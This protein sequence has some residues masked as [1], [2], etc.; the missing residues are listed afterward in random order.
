MQLAWTAARGRFCLV[1]DAVAA[2]G[3]GDG[4]FQLGSVTVTA[5]DG[6]VRRDDDTLAG[7]ALTMDAAVRNLHGLGVELVDAVNAAT[8]V[9]AGLIG[10]PDLGALHVGGPAD[11][12]VFDDNLEVERVLVA[13]KEVHRV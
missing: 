9:P 13:G 1:T 4:T 10:R 2:A 8:A 12:A 5:A 7:S 11:I 6:A 3:M